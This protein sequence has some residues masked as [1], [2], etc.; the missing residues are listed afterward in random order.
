MGRN[1]K[2]KTGRHGNID[3]GKIS[4]RFVTQRGVELGGLLGGRGG[5][6]MGSVELLL[7]A[8]VLLLI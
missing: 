6:G 3:C 5:G 2:S 4:S 7:K 8:H 1:L